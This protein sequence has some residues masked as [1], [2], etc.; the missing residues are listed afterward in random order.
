MVNVV[1]E[2]LE[3]S[4]NTWLSFSLR[5]SLIWGRSSTSLWICNKTWN[6]N[7]CS[8]K[9]IKELY[10]PDWIKMAWRNSR[11]E[12]IYSETG[13]PEPA[14]DTKTQHNS[15]FG[16]RKVW[17]YWIPLSKDI[18]LIVLGELELNIFS[19]KYGH[20]IA[21]Q[22]CWIN[23]DDHAAPSPKHW[24]LYCR[25]V[26]AVSY[27]PV[28]SLQ[29]GLHALVDHSHGDGSGLGTHW[30]QK[31]HI[32]T[33]PFLQAEF[34]LH[35]SSVKKKEGKFRFKFRQLYWSPEGQFICSL[36]TPYTH[37]S[38]LTGMVVICQRQHIKVH[39]S[40]QGTTSSSRI[41]LITNAG[42]SKGVLLHFCSN[43]HVY[44]SAFACK[45]QY[46]AHYQRCQMFIKHFQLRTDV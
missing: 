16:E 28:D 25:C 17:T 24:L 27:P 29:P 12:D 3:E 46:S 8:G 14:L 20:F 10:D 2:G 35:L 13:K 26:V 22:H 21:D 9:A 5:L 15:S 39:G 19:S 41:R 30:E 31:N 18:W 6:L 36:P 37:H 38:K 4:L 7:S 1:A 45:G 11:N 40:I 34:A 42:A 32:K 33:L 23:L 44:L 43:Y